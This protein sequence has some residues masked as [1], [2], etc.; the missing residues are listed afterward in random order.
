MREC[1]LLIRN[2]KV[3]DG[4]SGGK[5]ANIAVTN[6]QVTAIGGTDEWRARQEISATGLWITPGFIDIHTHYDIEVEL[7]PGLPES[8]RHGVTTVVMGNCSMSATYG[9]PSVLADIF[10]RVETIPREIAQEWA[11]QAVEHR[12]ARDYFDHLRKL[13]TGPNVACML[14]HSALRAH[15]MG[16]ERSLSEHATDVELD[17]M[18]E[19]A[20]AAL[21]AGCIGISVDMVHWHKVD[22]DF[23]GKPLPSHHASFEE[24]AMLAEVCRKR[25]AVFQVTPNPARPSSLIDILKLSTGIWRAPLRI[26]ILSAL[27]M[28]VMPQAWRLFSPLLFLCNQLL[29]CNI[30]FQTLAEPFT[31]YADGH[32]TPFFEEFP[33]GVK[34]NSERSA[35]G[36]KKLWQDANFRHQFVHDWK[37]SAPRTFHRDFNRMYIA[38]SETTIAE[39][40]GDKDPLEFFMNML[41]MHDT[42][43][44]WRAC[45]ANRRPEPRRKLLQHPHILPGFS[46]AGAHMKNL[47]FFDSALSVLR[48]AMQSGCLTAQ[49]AIARVTSEPAAWFNLNTGT[50][51]V[52]ARAD[53]NIIDPDRLYAPIPEARLVGGRM[54]KR[55]PLPAL[56]HVVIAGT[57]VVADGAPL[58]VLG[59]K[60]L[61]RILTQTN[62]TTS[63]NEALE[64][65]RSRVSDRTLAPAH[66]PDYWNIFLLKHQ[67]PGNVIFHCIAFMLMYFIPVFAITANKLWLL[68]LVPLS[69][70]VG[71][72]GHWLFEPS[73]I[74]QR[75]TVFSWRAFKSLH[76]MFASV[77][78]GRY[79]FDAARAR[80]EWNYAENFNQ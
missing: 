55:D 36:R 46:D 56:Q 61:G 80:E 32:V 37:H 49:Q 19:L 9:T 57:P 50:I 68:A 72:I 21:E 60:P 14:G 66:A 20:Q 62:P 79:K 13:S 47:A 6:G 51:K 23:A 2:G 33:S 7:T 74:D 65:F 71:L 27:D 26:T 63:A 31:I 64:R 45:S 22:G 1:D 69:Q 67:H 43:F 15:V 78:I 3:F 35:E 24:Y 10:S 75:D 18:R 12:N 17:K 52:G 39:A 38:D 29:G 41:E 28:D 54:V 73:P 76:F 59:T 77:L 42:Q 11:A 40:A 25:D 44:R 53:L 4:I 34:L 16:L 48:E 30:R 8:V 70:I 58:A 5:I